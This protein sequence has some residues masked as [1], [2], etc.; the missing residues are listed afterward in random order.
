MGAD[1]KKRELH[2]K[3]ALDVVRPYTEEQVNE[4]RY[5]CG[6][7]AALLANN[8]FFKVKRLCVDGKAALCTDERSFVSLLC[9]DGEGE[10]LFDGEKYKMTKGESYFCPAGMGAFELVGKLEVICSTL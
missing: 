9:L 5:S 6:Y 4:I 10:I 7:D 2:T 1:G 3:K 8:D